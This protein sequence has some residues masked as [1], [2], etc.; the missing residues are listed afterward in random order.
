M[1]IAICLVKYD[2]REEIPVIRYMLV[3]TFFSLVYL[4]ILFRGYKKNGQ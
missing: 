4:G 3:P 1:L 2:V